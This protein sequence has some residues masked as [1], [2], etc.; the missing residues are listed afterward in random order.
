VRYPQT[1]VMFLFSRPDKPFFGISN[2]FDIDKPDC[3]TAAGYELN[4]HFLFGWNVRFSIST[5]E[6]HFSVFLRTPLYCSLEIPR[7]T[8]DRNIL[9]LFSTFL[10]RFPK[11]F[12]SW[13]QFQSVLHRT[14]LYCSLDIPVAQWIETF[15]LS[16]LHFSTDSQNYFFPEPNFS[17]CFTERLSTAPWTSPLHNVSKY[18]SSLFYISHSIPKFFL[19]NSPTACASPNTSLLLI[20]HP[21]CTTY[22]IF[23]FLMLKRILRNGWEVQKRV[24][25]YYNWTIVQRG[26]TRNYGGV[27]RSTDF[28]SGSFLHDQISF[29]W[30]TCYKERNRAS[31]REL[32]LLLACLVLFW[33]VLSCFGLSCLVLAC[34]VLFWPVLSCFGLSCLVLFWLVLAWLVLSCFVFLCACFVLFC[35]ALARCLK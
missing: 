16:F 35:L 29:T 11:V 10:D 24:A 3:R 31:D 14:P 1:R 8:M 30:R 9:P 27:G 22:Q 21:R 34:L 20:G 12:F 32:W 18:S 2:K 13:T 4:S 6:F 25:E 19:L 15:F 26:C 7:C 23:E 5:V 28:F 33:L 17:L